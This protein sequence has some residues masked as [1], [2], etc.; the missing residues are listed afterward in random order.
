MLCDNRIKDRTQWNTKLKNQVNEAA[1][2]TE[3]EQPEAEGKNTAEIKKFQ[4]DE[5]SKQC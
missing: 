1:K 3:A 2:R 5:G 4:E